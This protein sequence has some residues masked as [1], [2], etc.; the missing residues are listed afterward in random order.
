MTEGIPIMDATPKKD[1]RVACLGPIELLLRQRLIEGRPNA[2]SI[3]GIN[4]ASKRATVALVGDSLVGKS[5]NYAE[6]TWRRDN[7]ADAKSGRRQYVLK[8]LS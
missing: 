6:R 3:P 5:F 2:Q 4:H 8:F 7:A 1:R